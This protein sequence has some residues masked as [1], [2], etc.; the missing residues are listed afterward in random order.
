MKFLFVT[1]RIRLIP[2]LILLLAF[3]GILL[4]AFWFMVPMAR[5]YFVPPP[6][7]AQDYTWS[8]VEI[9]KPAINS[10]P[11]N[12]APGTTIEAPVTVCFTGEWVAGTETLKGTATIGELGQA[13]WTAERDPEPQKQQ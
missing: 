6:P 13:T 4:A 7:P 5:A 10:A 2:L 1:G 11:L 8:Y 12:L 9:P 3:G